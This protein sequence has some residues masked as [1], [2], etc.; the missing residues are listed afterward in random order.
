MPLSET[1]ARL[2]IETRYNNALLVL[3][4]AE[5]Q[6]RVARDAERQPRLAV[7]RAIRDAH[8]AN[9]VATVVLALFLVSVCF[10][11]A[12]CVVLPIAAIAIGR[13]HLRSLLAPWAEYAIPLSFIG[14]MTLGLVCVPFAWIA[15]R[16]AMRVVE[17]DGRGPCPLDD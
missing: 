8:W 16:H 3:R 12:L 13:E 17:T 15:E 6:L 2:A 9:K 7:F 10:G 11:T 4:N 14:A 5:R 1:D